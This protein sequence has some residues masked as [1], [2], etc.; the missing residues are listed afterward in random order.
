MIDV[1]R[2]RVIQTTRFLIV[3]NQT[4]KNEKIPQKSEPQFFVIFLIPLAV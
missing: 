1:A 2:N 4:A 3:F